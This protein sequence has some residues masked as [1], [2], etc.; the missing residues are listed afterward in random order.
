M[1]LTPIHGPGGNF[2]DFPHT[3]RA[4]LRHDRE[5]LAF[6]SSSAAPR[7]IF[8]SPE[9][10]HPALAAYDQVIAELGGLNLANVAD[11]DAA[12]SS[13]VD[14]DPAAAKMAA[15]G[16]GGAITLAHPIFLFFWCPTLKSNGLHRWYAS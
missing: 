13:G 12:A 14:E 7:E 15:A 6:L 4:R 11:E 5:Q 16:R 2:F 3:T 9:I 1:P 8:L 10:A